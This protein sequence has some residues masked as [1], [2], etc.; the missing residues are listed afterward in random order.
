MFEKSNRDLSTSL[1]V[2][3][4]VVVMGA[5]PAM[6][7]DPTGLVGQWSFSETSGVVT[8]DGGPNALDGELLDGAQF[9]GGILGNGVQ[10]DGVDDY[11]N[12]TAAG[13]G[14]PT[15]LGGPAQ[16]TIS[17]W[18]KF[19][20]VTEDGEIF[21]IFYLGDGVDDAGYSSILIEVGHANAGNTRLYLT[22]WADGA[23][24]APTQCFDTGIFNHLN[25]DEWYNFVGVV[26]P[27]GNTGYLNGLELT[28]RHYN[29]GD[30]FDTDF[31]ADVANPNVAW[32]GT[33]LNDPRGDQFF[34]GR[35]DEVLV[36]DRLWSAAEALDYYNATVPEPA[37][38]IVLALG[39][40]ALLKRRRR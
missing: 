21:P 14:G 22:V 16:G 3:V 38:V 34:P 20:R 30:E 37:T 31:L 5:S 7:L 18:F 26:G 8:A 32:I 28:G 1:L 6:A 24:S 2:V 40:G 19:N 29:F 11:V 9:A 39:A 36:Y 35:I 17:V 33:I 25:T 27:G 12:V 4:V 13:G 15:A 10:L 23:S